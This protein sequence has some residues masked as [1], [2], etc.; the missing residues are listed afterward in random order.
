MRRPGPPV[1]GVG[2]HDVVPPGFRAPGSSP[3]GLGIPGLEGGGSY[4]GPTYVGVPAPQ[5]GGPIPGARWD[6]IR[7]P[8]LEVKPLCVL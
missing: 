6:P 7:P 8:G 5:R 1:Y 3:G 4:L 2:A